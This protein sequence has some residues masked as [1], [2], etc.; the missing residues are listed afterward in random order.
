M[1]KELSGRIALVTGSGRG[2]GRAT[3]L[4]LAA[5]GADLVVNYHNSDGP[6]DEV[7]HLASENGGG[8]R[9]RVYKADVSNEEEVIHMVEEVRAKWGPITILVNNA[10]ITREDRK[11]TRLNSS[12]LG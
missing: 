4:A 8:G 12:H 9:T 5:Q 11:S 1:K 3:A 7:C 6:A 2:I 10:G